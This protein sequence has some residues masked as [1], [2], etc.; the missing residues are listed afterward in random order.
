MCNSLV[1]VFPMSRLFLIVPAQRDSEHSHRGRKIWSQCQKRTLHSCTGET[2]TTIRWV[3]EQQMSARWYAQAHTPGK[4]IPPEHTMIRGRE[5]LAMCMRSRCLTRYR[6]GSATYLLI[7]WLDKQARS[8]RHRTLAR[9]SV[10]HHLYSLRTHGNDTL[11]G[12]CFAC[13]GTPCQTAA[14]GIQCMKS[15]ASVQNYANKN[16]PVR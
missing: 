15:T 2:L 16:D 12:D 9:R 10:C 14:A 4:F 3:C 13:S 11:C 5:T 6:W 7:M 8:E 1:H